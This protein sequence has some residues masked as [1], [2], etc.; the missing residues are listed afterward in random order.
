MRT[1]TLLAIALPN[2]CSVA[3]ERTYGDATWAV[4]EC[5]APAAFQ[6]RGASEPPARTLRIEPAAA[7]ASSSSFVVIVTD[8]GYALQEAEFLDDAGRAAYRDLR[9]LARE[10]FDALLRQVRAQADWRPAP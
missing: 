8:D 5:N 3:I 7:N 1:R 4:S 2:A 9:G 10:D 6:P